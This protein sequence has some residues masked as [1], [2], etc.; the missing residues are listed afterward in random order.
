M[1]TIKLDATGDI[2]LEKGDFLMVDGVEEIRQA[3]YLSLATNKREWFL[4]PEFGLDFRAVTGKVND[5][6]IRAAIIAAISQEERLELIEDLIINKDRQ[7]RRLS[8][9]FR[10]RI[11][12][13]ETIE[14]E[15]LLSA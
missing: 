4:N 7:S 9:F 2:A 14:G 1:K 5:S 12:S 15:V 10:V 13:G 6:Q 11:R 8:V 3:L